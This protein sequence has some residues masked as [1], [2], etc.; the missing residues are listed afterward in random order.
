[1]S[2]HAKMVTR[3]T[4]QYMTNSC[5]AN[6]CYKRSLRHRKATSRQLDVKSSA[7]LTSRGVPIR[8]VRYK[9][10]STYT[11][12]VAEHYR[13]LGINRVRSPSKPSARSLMYPSS[14]ENQIFLGIVPRYRS[15]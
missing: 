12:T 6:I 7:S 8:Y 3:L 11:V 5:C 13:R 1:M 9:S 14:E 15:I 10:Q 4:S 2:S